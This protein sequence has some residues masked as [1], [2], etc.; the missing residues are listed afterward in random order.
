[1]RTLNDRDE[2]LTHAVANAGT[3]ARTERIRAAIED[4]YKWDLTPVYPD[5]QAW[6]KAKRELTGRFAAVDPFKGR[7]RESA[8]ALYDCLNLVNTLH[9]ELMRLYCYASMHSDEDTRESGYLGMEQ[10][11][12]QIG[13]DLGARTAFIDPEILTMDRS[14]IDGFIV[15]EPRLAVYR[16]ALY[17][18]L[19]K[20]AHTLSEGEETILAN[21]GLI[22][23]GPHSVY[24]I[25]SDADFPFPEVVLQD[26]RTVKLDKANF[27]LHR[28]EP[29]REDRK[30]IFNAFF[31]TLNTYRRTF[32]AQLN[33]EVRKNIFFSRSRRYA[34]CLHRA[35]DGSNIPVEVYR[36]LIDNVNAHLQIFHR[37]LG[38]RKRMLGVDTLHYY[39]LYAPLV[40]DIDFTFSIEKAQE[41]TLAALAPLGEEY[42]R[43]AR[44][45]FASRWLDVFPSD[46]K[47]SGAYSNGSVY[48]VHPYILLNY[49]GKYDD[50]S[51]LAHELGHTMHSYLSN[52]TQ[53]YVNSQYSIFVA[54]VASTFNEA[55]LMEHMLR[56]LTDDAKRLSLLGNYLDGIRG[57]IFRQTQFSEFELR[58][59]ELAERGEALTGD[60]LNDL[61]AGIC[62]KYYGHDA[63]VC[64]VDDEIRAEWAHVPHFYYTFYVY[65]YA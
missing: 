56:A 3:A 58:I 11:M 51:T 27:S 4:K 63:G 5:D 53:N 7:I 47:R 62:R 57:T 61:Y 9:K 48:D 10:E 59:H 50:V 55:L 15:E 29:D 42:V 30:K 36:G 16:H 14:R 41:H 19:R 34:S 17:D 54:E 22:A 24:S 49:N 45:G 26:K 25:F 21:A 37:Y 60:S 8:A 35:L 2:L 65:Q 44:D 40:R 38:L 31:G 64:I 12:S 13:A 28:A 1:M 52:R 33:A 6:Q 20:K 18:M 46:G 39:D 43:V 23:D 32:G